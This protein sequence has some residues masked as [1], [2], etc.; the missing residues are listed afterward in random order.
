MVERNSD[1]RK[2]TLPY[3]PFSTFCTALEY[4]RTHGIPDKINASVLPNMS[5]GMV[6][7]VLLALR[8]LGLVDEKG[9]PQPALGQLVGEKTRR[10]TLARI[11]PHAYAELF[12]KVDLAKASPSTL[13]N[14]LREQNV[15]GA[16]HQK[17]KA[18]LIKAAQFAGLPLS[19]HLAR[20]TRRTGPRNKGPAAGTRHISGEE[21]SPRTEPQSQMQYSKAV[22]L[23]QAGGTL[24]LSGNFDPFTLRG[25]ERD[26]VYRLADLISDFESKKEKAGD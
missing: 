11:L 21:P 17:A 24:V 18:F 15:R 6:S 14:A 9:G 10:Q 16:T 1:S 22:K 26:L 5:R 4:L 13:D 20:R 2:A 23:P 19:N 8:F 7:H 25:D 3:P 12:K